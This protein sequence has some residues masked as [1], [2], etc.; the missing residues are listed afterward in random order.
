MQSGALDE[1]MVAKPD[2]PYGFAK[3]AL[4]KQLEFLQQRHPFALAWARLFYLHGDGQAPTS[5]LPLLQKAVERGDAVF[6]MSGGEQLRDYLP[7]TE[8]ARHLVMMAIHNMDAGVVNLCSGQPISVRRFTEGML[9]DR[10]W[11]IDLN[12]GYYPYPDYEPFA[13]WGRRSRLDAL[14]EHAADV[15][16]SQAVRQ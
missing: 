13:F 14:I 16:R 10:G 3:D 7:V 8:T 2:N 11:R 9:A 6:N 5:L 1:S 4:R 15:S 12:L